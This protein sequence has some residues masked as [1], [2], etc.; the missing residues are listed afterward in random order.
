MDCRLSLSIDVLNLGLI[1]KRFL[2]KGNSFVHLSMMKEP[3][4]RARY[5]DRDLEFFLRGIYC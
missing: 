3:G 1:S 2:Q 5:G 4:E